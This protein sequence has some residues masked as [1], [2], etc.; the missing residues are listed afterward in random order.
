MVKVALKA[1]LLFDTFMMVAMMIGYEE[2]VDDSLCFFL[3]HNWSIWLWKALKE[4]MPLN[5]WLKLRGEAFEQEI[6][7]FQKRTAKPTQYDLPPP[8]FLAF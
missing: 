6:R 5:I 2:D 8:L 4:F 7:F 3:N 1:L